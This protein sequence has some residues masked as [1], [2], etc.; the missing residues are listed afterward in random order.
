[1]MHWFQ[2]SVKLLKKRR[3]GSR[4]VR[5]YSAAQTPLDRLP[6]SAALQILKE[7]RGKLNPFELAHSIEKQLTAIWEQANEHHNPRHVPKLKLGYLFR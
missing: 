3:V 7:Q 6:A 1:M 2:P 5:Q 4:L